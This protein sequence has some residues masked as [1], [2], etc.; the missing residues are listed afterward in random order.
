MHKPK[1]DTSTKQN[2][3]KT[4]ILYELL[5]V[6]KKLLSGGP[7]SFFIKNKIKLSFYN[8]SENNESCVEQVELYKKAA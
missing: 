5:Y 6:L 8:T 7:L 4:K 3:E 1:F 2:F